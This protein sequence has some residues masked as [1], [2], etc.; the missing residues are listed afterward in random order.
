MSVIAQFHRDGPEICGEIPSDILEKK[1]QK[2]A[3][4]ENLTQFHP[5]ISVGDAILLFLH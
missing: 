1:A 4:K 2:I 3:K 5:R